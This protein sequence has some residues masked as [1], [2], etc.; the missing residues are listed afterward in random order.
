MPGTR[1]RLVISS[2]APSAR[3]R[4]HHRAITASP[5]ERPRSH[6]A[7]SPSSGLSEAGCDSVDDDMNGYLVRRQGLGD[8]IKT[9]S[10]RAVD[11][12]DCP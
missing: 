7:S 5:R 8:A 4:D 2:G 1:A 9:A 11:L 6:R 12:R 10:R 3:E